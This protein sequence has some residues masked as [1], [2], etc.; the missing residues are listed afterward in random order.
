MPSRKLEAAAAA[1]ASPE[2][3]PKRDKS[4]NAAAGAG[5]KS[6][7]RDAATAAADGPPPPPSS[8]PSKEEAEAEAGR[9]KKEKRRGGAKDGV[10][11]EP[12]KAEGTGK[13]KKRKE[14]KKKRSAEESAPVSDGRPAAAAAAADEAGEPPKRKKRKTEGE[15]AGSEDAAKPAGS[16][17]PAPVSMAGV[18]DETPVEDS[19]LL[20]TSYRISAPTVK[21]LQ[22]RGVSSLFPI[23][24]KTFNPIFDG[25]DLVGRARTGTGKTLAFALPMIERLLAEGSP[26]IPRNGPRVLVLGKN[27]YIRARFTGLTAGAAL[28]FMFVLTSSPIAWPDRSFSPLAPICSADAGVGEA[29]GGR[30]PDPDFRFADTALRNGVDIIVGTPGRITDHLE[31]GSLKLRNLRFLTLDECDQMLDIGFKDDM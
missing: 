14:K 12:E 1:G 3:P 20:V 24:A 19:E 2:K 27:N 30:V 5:K 11:G 28:V 4:K 26:K 22:D 13:E 10:A 18:Q 6:K 8:S 17:G 31:R 25:K 21:K 9:R 16:A 23:Q 15:P 29:S 7:K